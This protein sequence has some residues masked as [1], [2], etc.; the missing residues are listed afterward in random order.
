M[1]LGQDDINQLMGAAVIGVDGSQLGVVDSLYR[2]MDDDQPRWAAVSSGFMG[3]YV[4]LVPLLG[5]ELRDGALHVPYD[6]EQLKQAPHRDPGSELSPAE[7]AD[8]FQH[9]GI[10][11]QRAE[12]GDSGHGTDPG[13]V[14]T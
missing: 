9:F 4:T 5:A 1:S 14:S 3:N 8:L 12:P 2:G 7:E 6:K 13:Q 10:A 11:Y